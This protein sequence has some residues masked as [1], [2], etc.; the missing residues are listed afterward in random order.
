MDVWLAVASKRE[1]RDYAGRPVP[2]DVEQRI[3]EAGRVA[4]SSRNTQS[5]RFILVADPDR[6]EQLADAVYASGNVRGAA[7]VMAI[8][9]WG[10]GPT[11]FDVGR[12]AQN[13]MLVAWEDGVGSCPNGIASPDQAAQVLCLGEDERVVTVLTFGY[14]ARARDPHRHTP[15]EWV[16]RADRRP[17][18]EVVQRL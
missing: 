9:A 13:M 8:V 3:L 14:P 7:L 10:R 5:R 12:A 2:A 4:G 17:F 16:A 11:A 15:E 18:A 1:V 6:R